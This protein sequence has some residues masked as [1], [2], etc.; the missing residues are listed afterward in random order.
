MIFPFLLLPFAFISRLRRSW[1]SRAMIVFLWVIVSI[2][3]SA[4]IVRGTRADWMIYAVMSLVGPALIG[5]YVAM[6]DLQRA[7]LLLSRVELGIILLA[8]IGVVSVLGGVLVTAIF[9][10]GFIPKRSVTP[11]GGPIATGGVL[12]L[13]LPKLVHDAFLRPSLRF[14]ALLGLTAVGILLTGSRAIVLVGMITSALVILEVNLRSRHETRIVVTAG[15]L[16]IACMGL[17]FAYSTLLERSAV[18]RLTTGLGERDGDVMRYQSA[19]AALYRIEQFPVL[20]SVPG[21]T[22]PWF[23][24]DYSAVAR[25]STTVDGRFSLVEPHNLFLLLGVDFGLLGLVSFLSLLVFVLRRLFRSHPGSDMPVHRLYALGIIAFLFQSF[26]SSGIAVNSRIATL[27]WMVLG[28][29]VALSYV[30]KSVP[31]SHAP[32][33]AGRLAGDVQHSSF[34]A[35]SVA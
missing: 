3:L 15:L 19:E 1:A 4:F 16:A 31:K 25:A 17:F 21:H 20:G 6:L 23:R 28:G 7:K 29:A 10:W 30:S 13:L 35:N 24:T 18:A 9:G 2:A 22:Y 33:P 32:I 12:L 26:G 8:G 14:G 34:K 5:V 11:V 27:F